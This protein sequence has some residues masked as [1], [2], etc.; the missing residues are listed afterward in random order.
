[1]KILFVVYLSTYTVADQ[2]LKNHLHCM[3]VD[4]NM[5]YAHLIAIAFLVCSAV[6][7]ISTT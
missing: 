7:K 1:M 6:D 5:P 2:K 3:V 4:I